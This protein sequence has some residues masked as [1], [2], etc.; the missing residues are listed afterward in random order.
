MLLKISKKNIYKNIYVF[1]IFLNF[2]KSGVIDV[3]ML[4]LD[5]ILVDYLWY[6]TKIKQIIFDK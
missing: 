5:S 6:T 1:Y 2:D 3:N 4:N